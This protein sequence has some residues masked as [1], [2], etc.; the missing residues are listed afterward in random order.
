MRHLIRNAILVIV[1]LF[2][3]G[4]SLYPPKEKLR[5][6]KDLAGGVSLVYNVD[7]EQAESATVID[8]TIAVLKDR[9]NPSGLFEID[10]RKQGTDQIEIT[11]P[12]PTE[13]VKDLKRAYE[14]EL[15]KLHDYELDVDAFEVAMR[16][17]GAERESA[18]QAM[19][20]TPARKSLLQPVYDALHEVDST[21]KAY[22]AAK[23]TA[24]P[25]ELNKLLEAA[26]AAEVALDTA[27][28]RVL[29]GLVSVDELR[30]IMEL[31]SDPVRIRDTKAMT[32]TLMP[33]RREKALAG[34]KERL[35][36]VTGGEELLNRIAAAHD[37]YSKKR[38]GLDDPADLQRLLQGAGVLT[39]RIAVTPSELPEEVARLRN[40]LKTRGA[41]YVQS[42]KA[43]WYPMHKEDGWFKDTA[44]YE[45]MTADPAAYFA[46]NY[47]LVA[48]ARDGQIYFLL[49]DQPGL[50]LTKAE[51]DWALTNSGRTTDQLGRPAIRFDLDAQGGRLMGDLTEKNV[52][53]PMAV[54]LDDRVYT[55]PN[56]NSRIAG[57]GI[58]EGTFTNE[59]IDY[60]IKTMA[61]GSLQAKLS[62][63]PI[64]VSTQGPEL[65]K[66]NLDRGLK[67]CVVSFIIVGAFMVVYYFGPGLVAV[68]GMFA[69][70]IMVL[71]A[72]SL[73]QAAFTLPGIAG[74]ALTFGVAVD[75]NVLIYERLR[76]EVAAGKDIRT[77]LRLAYQRAGAA[78]IDSNVTH[79]I[80]TVILGYT[81]T[82]EIKGFAITLGI[83]VIATMFM[84]LVITRV[85]MVLL[86]D[87]L[88]IQA[89]KY[90]L[91][92]VIP[93]L[94]RAMHPHVKWLSLR[95]VFWGFSA[96]AC[97][98]SIILIVKE[99]PELLDSEF[100]GGTSI[101]ISLVEPAKA[102]GSARAPI[103]MTRHQVEERI[104][105]IEGT[106]AA[107]KELVNAD[108]VP[109][110]ADADGVTSDKFT[111]RT[112]IADSELIGHAIVREFRDNIET[113]P[114]LVFE[115]WNTAS[116]ADAPVY[117]VFEGKLG[118]N[119]NRDNVQNP[120]EKFI[121]GVVIVLDGLDKNTPPPTRDELKR[122]LDHVRDQGAFP[123][124][125]RRDSQ[126]IVI[127][128]TNNA[129]K[130]A[131]VVVVDP[132]VSAY[133]QAAWRTQ[134]ADVEWKLVQEGLTKSSTLAGV[135]SFSPQVAQSFRTQA[136]IASLLSL[137]GISIYVWVRF[138]S[139][140]YAAA[141]LIPLVHDVIVALGFVG[142]SS[143][144]YDAFPSVSA[145]GIRPYRIDMGMVAAV[146]T[147]IGYSLSDTIVVL[148]RIRENRGKLAYAS[149]SVIN[150]AINQT[151]SRT[152]ITSGTIIFS[153][154]V[155]LLYGG[156][157]VASFS[158]TLLIGIIVGTYSS[159][160]IAAPFVW[161]RHPPAAST[162]KRI[163]PDAEL[164]SDTALAGA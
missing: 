42:D 19:M 150:D 59:E 12:L 92:L 15:A 97:V 80:T 146:L 89:M 37:T 157:S 107:F 132:R 91:P 39:F 135:Q 11:M 64:S 71:G 76:E 79:L 35:S 144:L 96:A 110:N 55:A 153:L 48:E 77:A 140:R 4:W 160:A 10:F 56:L 136:I 51:G 126:L 38:R 138:G 45:A 36:G 112:T 16:K 30:D 162:P 75:S 122:R 43:R 154:V 54:L 121:G 46:A 49:F 99:G 134:L 93:A 119:I 22:A 130:S 129:V 125:Q 149:A 84:S 155:I 86:I 20:D 124:A 21:R 70:A 24:T 3:C 29:H 87:K 34:F 78:I 60:V 7:V 27:R 14:A 67:A 127:D 98:A 95:W 105:K 131:A 82:P 116:S 41:D 32:V 31:P 139:V 151:M 88:H 123:T 40:E 57:S 147:I 5:L 104:A 73:Q 128:G 6:G 103:K 114:A 108:I 164:E 145:I 118:A 115:K 28:Q 111:I 66:D 8:R 17:T 81:G 101:T 1:V 74:I 158:Y 142:L 90:S 23:S 109:L 94:Q 47:R 113:T 68:V 2:V 52:G 163:T 58:I 85:I 161:M 141:A 156:D 106:D 100:R 69:T 65:G 9:V 62:P 63:K 33:S 102:D 50:R 18:L 25:E 44:S 137:L 72:M 120:V 83:G 61:A 53:K 133:D 117:P 143:V 26:G 148:D 159:I 152:F 13:E